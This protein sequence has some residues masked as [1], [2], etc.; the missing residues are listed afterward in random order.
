MASKHTIFLG[1]GKF[2]KIDDVPLKVAYTIK[3]KMHSSNFSGMWNM[4][5]IMLK[6]L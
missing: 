4:L 5:S 6:C 3:S 1:C 2:D